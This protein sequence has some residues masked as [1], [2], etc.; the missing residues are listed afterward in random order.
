M[1]W[2]SSTKA[3]LFSLVCLRMKGEE[4]SRSEKEE[5]ASSK[6][7]GRPSGLGAGG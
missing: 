7:H 3:V 5:E 6:A 2:W 4:A 1:V